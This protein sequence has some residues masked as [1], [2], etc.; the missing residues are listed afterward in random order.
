MPSKKAPN[1]KPRIAAPQRTERVL[2]RA[3]TSS[4]ARFSWRVICCSERPIASQA[5][6]H[7]HP[8]SRDRVLY[9][10]ESRY[11]RGDLKALVADPHAVNAPTEARQDSLANQITV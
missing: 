8:G 5:C 7:R 10:R 4:D 1:A 9:A 2:C 6:T 3:P 11:F